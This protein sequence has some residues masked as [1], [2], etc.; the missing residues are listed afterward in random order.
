MA[1]KRG[2]ILGT[3]GPVP[4]RNLLRILSKQAEV[5]MAEYE[6]LG[7]TL[8]SVLGKL[9]IDDQITLLIDDEPI[10]LNLPF[11]IKNHESE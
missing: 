5:S 10:E 8:L 7:I 11:S 2:F 4:Q 6:G 3:P 9:G 1:S